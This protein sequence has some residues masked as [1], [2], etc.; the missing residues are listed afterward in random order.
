[1]R[2]CCL[3][4]LFSI[5]RAWR[6]TDELLTDKRLFFEFE[7]LEVE[8]VWFSMM[9]HPTVGPSSWTDGF[10]AAFAKR[11]GYQMVTFDQG[12]RR[13]TELPLSLLA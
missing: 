1:M 3:P 11:Y 7:P 5:E 12:F 8:V 6:V 4:E 13:W 9:S 2:E 10:L